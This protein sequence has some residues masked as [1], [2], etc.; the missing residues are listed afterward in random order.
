[1]SWACT[2]DR[3]EDAD[4][5]GDADADVVLARLEGL[6]LGTQFGDG[7]RGGDTGGGRPLTD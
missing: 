3:D 6:L 4:V 7:P 5:E 2:A 1:V